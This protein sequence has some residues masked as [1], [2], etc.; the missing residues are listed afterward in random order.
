[1][2]SNPSPAEETKRLWVQPCLVN[3]LRR[4]EQCVPSGEN[5]EFC[6]QGTIREMKEKRKKEKDKIYK[7]VII[8]WEEGMGVK[9]YT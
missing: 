5:K 1:M 2:P 6:L 8:V 9:L 7:H 3:D 4:E